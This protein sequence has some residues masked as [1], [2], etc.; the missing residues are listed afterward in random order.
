MFIA[1]VFT[2]AKQTTPIRSRPTIYMTYLFLQPPPPIIAPPAQGTNF[3]LDDKKSMGKIP[4]QLLKVMG[5]I[6][7]ELGVRNFFRRVSS[8]TK[9]SPPRNS[10]L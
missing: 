2:A 9:F 3:E 7:P 4:P 10:T 1:A 6:A 5:K 8:A